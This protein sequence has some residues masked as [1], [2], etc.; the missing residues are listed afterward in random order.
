LFKSVVD[1]RFVKTIKTPT[2]ILHAKDD[3]FMYPET[4]P[5]AADLPD[6]VALE[7]SQSGD[8]VGFVAGNTP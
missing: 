5:T 2:L 8:H 3:P 7:L 6:N 4:A 1:S